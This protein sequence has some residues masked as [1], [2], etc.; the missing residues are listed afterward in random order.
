MVDGIGTNDP[1]HPLT[2]IHAFM[3]TMMIEYC[4]PAVLKYSLK[5][6]NIVRIPK[7]L[8][9]LMIKTCKLY[10]Y[11]WLWHSDS[12]KH[13]SEFLFADSMICLGQKEVIA[14]L[15]GKI[16]MR[17]TEIFCNGRRGPKYSND[18]KR[19]I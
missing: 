11:Y 17:G 19:K 13:P 10:G 2:W 7:Y 8:M 1:A 4:V 6:K 18:R 9:K 3:M 16:S 15:R 12:F 14:E 5:S